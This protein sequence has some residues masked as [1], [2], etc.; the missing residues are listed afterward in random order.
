MEPDA[1]LRRAYHELLG[2]DY[3]RMFMQHVQLSGLAAAYGSDF[4]KTWQWQVLSVEHSAQTGTPLTFQPYLI[5]DAGS[6][7]FPLPRLFGM[8]DGHLDIASFVKNVGATFLLISYALGGDRKAENFTLTGTDGL[9]MRT[10]IWQVRYKR[11]GRE[12]V[13]LPLK[14]GAPWDDRFLAS[15]AFELR[16]NRAD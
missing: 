16:E 13:R 9:T 7:F 12:V 10:V 5:T 15:A 3:E 2:S 4:E 6:A 14:E 1:N 8:G 11:R